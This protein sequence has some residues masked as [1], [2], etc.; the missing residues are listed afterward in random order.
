VVRTAK[1]IFLDRDGVLNIPTIINGKSFAPKNLSSFRLYPYTKASL[2]LLQNVG[3]K[4]IVV[5]NQPDVGNKFIKLSDLKK[6]HDK[7][8]KECKIDDIFTCIHSQKDECNCRKPKTG[9][10]EDAI[11]KYNIDISKSFLIG[12]RY[13]DIMAAKNINC[14]SIFIDRKYSEVYPQTQVMTVKS[15]KKAVD[16]ILSLI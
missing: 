13:S 4:I 16:F 12:D 10:L 11:Y 6:M 2:E 1:A 8:H 14:D 5:T 3:Y 15:L 7:L 9:M